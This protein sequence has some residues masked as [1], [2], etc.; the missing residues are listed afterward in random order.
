MMGDC[1][2]PLGVEAL[3]PAYSFPAKRCGSGAPRWRLTGDTLRTW[4]QSRCANCATVEETFCAV[5]SMAS[6]SSSLGTAHPLLN[7]DHCLDPAQGPPN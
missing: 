1:C 7:Y 4:I 6:A 3:W 5:S 2:T